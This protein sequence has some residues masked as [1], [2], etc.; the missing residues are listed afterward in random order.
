MP[1]CQEQVQTRV[2]R[3]LLYQ[4]VPSPWTHLFKNRALFSPSL[5]AQASQ[6]PNLPYVWCHRFSTVSSQ[7]AT[8][9]AACCFPSCFLI[10]DASEHPF[11]CFYLLASFAASCLPLTSAHL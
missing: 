11:L 8:A 4:E 6:G 9:G 3:A 5:H 1:P 7:M 10:T 2:C